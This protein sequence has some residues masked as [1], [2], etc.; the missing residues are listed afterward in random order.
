M[1]ILDTLVLQKELK[2]YLIDKT[3]PNMTGESNISYLATLGV[4]NNNKNTF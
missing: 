4:F 2:M 1:V 3:Q